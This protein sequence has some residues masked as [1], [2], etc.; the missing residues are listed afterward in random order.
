MIFILET[1][2]GQIDVSEYG[3]RLLL[4]RDRTEN[5]RYGCHER[6]HM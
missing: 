5:M 2:K 6:S 4:V 3:H 1:P